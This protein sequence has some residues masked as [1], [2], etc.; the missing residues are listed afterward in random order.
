MPAGTAPNKSTW[1]ATPTP[2]RP[3][4]SDFNGAA[5]ENDEENPPDPSTMPTAELLNTLSFLAISYGKIA[6]NAIITVTGGNPPVIIGVQSPRT[7]VIAGTFTATR[8]SAGDVSITWPANTFPASQ[9]APTVS[10]NITGGVIA[11]H[12]Y[13]YSAENI[14]NGVRVTTSFDAVMTD[15]NFTVQVR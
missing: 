10:L 6:P 3:G 2:Y 1:D 4:T 12:A 9:A 8:N 15:M 13:A 11:G 7:G 14:T 5:L